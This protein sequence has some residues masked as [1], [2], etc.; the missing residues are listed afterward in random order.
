MNLKELSQ[1]YWLSRELE[2]ETARLKEAEQSDNDE[3]AVEIAERILHRTKKIREEKVKI[4]AYIDEIPDSLT[5]QIFVQR[6]ICRRSWVF[7][8][9][10]LGIN[11]EAAKKIVYRYIDRH[12]QK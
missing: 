3:L 9:I 6:F 5:R 10:K 8:G 11:D 7:I 12:N 1:I 2:E 4:E